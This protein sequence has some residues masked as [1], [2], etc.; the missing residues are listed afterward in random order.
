MTPARLHGGRLLQCSLY[1]L[2]LLP[3]APARAGETKPSIRL[4]GFA[5]VT[6]IAAEGSEALT[7]G[8]DRVRLDARGSINAVTDY[9][10][11]LD[12]SRTSFDIDKD[13]DSDG[14]I[15]DV[16]IT[17]KPTGM[18]SASAG[19]FKTPVGMEFNT[20]GK[21]LDFV[22]RGLGQA[23]VFERNAGVMLHA[24]RIGQARFGFAAGIFNA[25][26]NRANGIGDPD[27]GADYTLAGRLSLTP[28]SRL[29]AQVYA[30]TALTSIEGQ[31]NITLL[32]AAARVRPV[33]ALSIKAEYMSRDDA[34]SASADGSD[35]YLQA[36]Y[37]AHPRVEPV[38]KYEVLDLAD[39][40]RDQA[41]TTLGCNLYL[42]P[43]LH[44]R[45][46]IMVNY[47]ISDLG[48][49]DALQLLFQIDY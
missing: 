10:L 26:P 19:K 7:F 14:I 40:T 16:V 37:L 22:K 2:L 42:S 21:N 33:A 35:Y 49:K 46:K 45:S 11:Q 27:Q 13:G 47:V 32:G 30:G 44:R 24:R 43:E 3:S 9:H 29:H 20:A 25:G 15:K 36:G 34:N 41:N 48:G 6:A 8:Y 5:Q 28:D 39:D 31:Q 1:L 17:Y 4:G 12:F 23:L 18:I 38:V